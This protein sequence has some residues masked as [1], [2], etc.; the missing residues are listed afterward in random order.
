MRAHVYIRTATV[1]SLVEKN[2]KSALKANLNIFFY[3]GKISQFL[4][5]KMAGILDIGHFNIIF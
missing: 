3:C 4:E 2:G 5:K 1:E